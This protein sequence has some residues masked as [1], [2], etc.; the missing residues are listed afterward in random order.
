M[1]ITPGL[2]TM[3]CRNIMLIVISTLYAGYILILLVPRM[4]AES[5]PC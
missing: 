1:I 5:F 2:L 4:V 3:S